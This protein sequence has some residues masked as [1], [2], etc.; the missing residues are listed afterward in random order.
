M[1]IEFRQGCANAENMLESYFTSLRFSEDFL[2][3]G[4][5]YVKTTIKEVKLDI[6][7]STIEINTNRV[8]LQQNIAK[9][10]VPNVDVTCDQPD[11]QQPILIN[12]V[13]APNLQIISGVQPRIQQYKCV[14]QVSFQIM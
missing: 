8:M 6:P 13:S 4:K 3:E 1:Y 9:N 11:V 5:V 2:K 14:L 7:D 12:D 10:T